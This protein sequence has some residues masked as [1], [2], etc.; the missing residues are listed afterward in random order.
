MLTAPSMSDIKIVLALLRYKTFNVNF[1]RKVISF[2]NIH[3]G[4]FT[5]LLKNGLFCKVNCYFLYVIC[6]FIAWSKLFFSYTNII[7]SCSLVMHPCRQTQI[8]FVQELEF[9]IL[10]SGLAKK[11][12]T[13]ILN[14]YL[15]C[16]SK[17]YSKYHS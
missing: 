10:I 7:R 5:I 17:N 8:Y 11:N 9:T 3:F 1:L 14:D 4:F 15:P 13:F 12:K 16:H 2:R 6:S